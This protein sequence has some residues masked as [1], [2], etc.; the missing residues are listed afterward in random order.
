MRSRAS[1]T[2]RRASCC[3][4]PCELEPTLE[5]RYHAARAAWRMSE[6][7]DRLGR[8]DARC[9][10]GHAQAGDS[11]V[12]GKALTALAEVALLR[13]GDLTKATE[14][15][16]AALEALPER[17]SL[18]RARGAR[19]D[20][21][22]DRRLRDA[23][24][25]GRRGR[26]RSPS[27]S[28]RKDLEAQALE[29]LAG[30]HRHHDR[31]DE[32]EETLRRGLEL[33]EES[34]SIVARAQALHSLGALRLERRETGIGKEQLE[35]ATSLFAEVGDAWMLGRTLNSLA[36]A[37]E[38]RG[39]RRGGGAAAARGDP[40]AEAAR[41]PRRAL[42]EPARRSPRCSSGSGRLDEAERLALEAIETVAEHDISLAGDD[43]DVA[44][45]RPGGAGAAT[46]RRRRS[47]CTRSRS[48]SRPG[49]A[50]SRSGSLDAA[51]GVP[52][53]A[54]PRRGGGAYARG[55]CAE[56]APARRRSA[57]AFASKDRANRLRRRLVRRL[58]DHRR[59]ALELRA[60]AFASGSARSVPSP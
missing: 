20:R 44:R 11:T 52:P 7:P 22:V 21:V 45:A 50:A 48:S 33:A 2:A 51:G 28:S 6:L 12:E 24:A 4:A 10:K 39:R 17:R 43:D 14:L 40:A 5:R 35:E 49:S 16:D 58:G 38:Q 18:R 47:S 1:R 3:S 13:E 30:V 57:H 36:W 55:A 34:G 8:D 54:R 37:A 19:P 41:G 15:I 25:H 9:W 31:L 59:R 27:G 53:R 42:R 56:L 32:A 23:G 60:S 26:S 46:P 29:Q